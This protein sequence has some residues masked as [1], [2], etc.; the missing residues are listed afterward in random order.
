MNV[1]FLLLSLLFFFMLLITF[2]LDLMWHIIWAVLSQRL[3]LGKGGIRM[4]PKEA[5]QEILQVCSYFTISF[6]LQSFFC[7]SASIVHLNFDYHEQIVIHI[8]S[9]IWIWFS[10]SCFFF[11]D[12]DDENMGSV[13]G[14]ISKIV[15]N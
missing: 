8:C 7:D 10:F 13:P 9:F 2:F 15:F 3:G 4:A 5:L 12:Y 1:V 11:I 6:L 14:H